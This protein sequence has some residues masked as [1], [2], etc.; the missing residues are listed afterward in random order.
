MPNSKSP[1]RLLWLLPVALIGVGGIG[2]AAMMQSPPADLDLFRYVDSAEEAVAM[3]RDWKGAG[4]KR[5]HI[6][7]RT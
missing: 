3:I 4:K 7:G 1:L 5:E 2:V 6:P